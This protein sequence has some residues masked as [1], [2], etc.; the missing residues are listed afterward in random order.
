MILMALDLNCFPLV[1]EPYTSMGLKLGISG[2]EVIQRIC[3]FKYDE[4]VRQISPVIDARSVGYQSTLIA[5]KVAKDDVD[6]AEQYLKEHPGVSHGYERENEFNIWVTLS[7]PP[8]V[9]LEREL[10]KI[11]I[12]TGAEALFALPATKVFKLRTNFGPEDS[13]TMEDNEEGSAGLSL[14]VKLSES[15]KKI[16]NHL[17]Q[18]LPLKAD[19]FGAFA[20]RLDISTDALLQQCISLK[21]RGVIRRYG[22]SINHYKAGYKANAM[23]C[24]IV[25]GNRVDEVGKKLASIRQVSHCYERQTN[26]YWSYNLFVMI[27]GNSKKACLDVVHKISDDT[28]L[29][30][31]TAL[32]STKEFKKTRIYYRI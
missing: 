10:D 15:D 8:R 21:K 13:G 32:F 31:Y 1:K 25:P 11:S 28:G 16:I 18:D 12:E 23:T 27:H 3:N 17:Q 29:A 26:L 14:K 7:L 5:I 19:P 9:K 30:N 22:A 20:K 4:I 24:W 2:D 6:S